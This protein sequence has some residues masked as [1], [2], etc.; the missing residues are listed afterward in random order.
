MPALYREALLL[1]FPSLYEGFG[2][3]LVEAMACGCPVIAS[4]TSSMPEVC[5][6]AAC[7]ID[8]GSK[9]S[10]RRSIETLVADTGLRDSLRRK[11][12]ARAAQFS[13]KK[14]AE[15]FNH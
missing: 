6:D 4:D 5:G 1:V 14:A 10:I 8:P 2:I 15:S 3:P 13:W 7:Y 12:Y 9:E 11:G